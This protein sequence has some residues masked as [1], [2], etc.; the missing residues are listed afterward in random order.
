MINPLDILLIS[1]AVVV[2]FI[3][4]NDGVI[5]NA[6]KI[7]NLITSIILTNLVLNNLYE[8]LLFFKQAD[9]IVKLASFAVLLILFMVCIG[10]FIELISEQIEVDEI[11]KI[12]DNLGSLLIGFIKG[13]VIIS[14]MMF[15]L[16]LTPLSNESKETINN[17]IESESILF[18][19][20][21][22]FKDFLFK[23]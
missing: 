4:Y 3:S 12:V 7:I 14:M 16:D 8:Q 23:S 22:I 9:S 15:I 20:I 11:D 17:K 18:K 21:K 5:K 6:S 10:F 13:I 1:F 19:P 2:A